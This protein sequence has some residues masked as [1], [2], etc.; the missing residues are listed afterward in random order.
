M[1]SGLTPGTTY[2]FQVIS[3]NAAGA[4]ATSASYTFSTPAAAASA[5]Y[6]GYVAFW[7]VSNT[8]VVISWSTDVNSNTAVGYGTTA[9]LGQIF[10]NASASS[11]TSHGA[12]LIGLTP[13]TRYY[14]VA[15]STGANGATGY[16]TTYSFTT[17]GTAPTNASFTLSASAVA[18]VAG[19]SGTSTVTVTPVNG[20]NGIVTL[21]GVGWPAGLQGFWSGTVTVNVGASV[22]PGTYLW[23]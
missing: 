12:V 3:T 17:T 13:G 4:S 1:L 19:G 11:T 20:F 15:Q 23:R 22:A 8:G 9:A 16:S 10:T 2:S 7:G 14:F 18:A 21:A 6:V 5:P